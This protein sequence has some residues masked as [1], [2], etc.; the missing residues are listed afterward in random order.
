[1]WSPICDVFGT[2][3]VSCGRVRTIVV[4]PVKKQFSDDGYVLIMMSLSALISWI[5]TKV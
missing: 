5:L 1:M 3:E 4:K 2:C